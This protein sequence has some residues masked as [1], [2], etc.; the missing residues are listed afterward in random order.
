MKTDDDKINLARVTLEAARQQA[1][2]STQRAAA[3]KSSHA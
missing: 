2:K 3:K 1:A